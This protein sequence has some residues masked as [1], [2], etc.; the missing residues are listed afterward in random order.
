MTK[1]VYFLPM[2][3]I[4]LV[5]FEGAQTLDVTG[6]AEVFAAT[7][8]ELEEDAYQITLAAV[9]GKNIRMSSGIVART[10]DLRRV[11]PGR[12]DTVIVA[13][14]EQPHVAAA[15][16]DTA[17]LRWLRRA[18]GKVRR[19]ASVCSGAFVL[20]AA[21][22][23]DGLRA[24]THWSACDQLALFRPQVTVDRDAVFV[25]EGSVWTSAG[26]T[27]GI[28]MA[29]A[30]VED[31]RGRAVAD[32]VAGRLVLYLRRPGFQSQFSDALV[33]Q[34]ARSA[35]LGSVVAW[36]RAHL[37]DAD[38]E[39]LARQAGLSQRTFHRRCLAHLGT[40]PAKLLDKLRV[41][42]ARTLLATTQL[43][44]KTLATSC[45]FGSAA[46]MKRAF[47]RE[48]GMAPRDYKMLHT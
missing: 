13:G 10:R 42:H 15:A 12:G 47:A 24:T 3:R 7:N 46:R 5:A 11:R 14:G 6:P 34:S 1:I 25:R 4:L 38:L 20:A 36:A 16:R 26:V 35:P 8:R 48:L 19:M 9:G 28:D 18:N 22:I 41:E 44:L 43:P 39:R 45:G 32:A 27:T 29:L 21:G 33:A 40:T 17:C 37:R 31:D 30:M 23:L 2:A